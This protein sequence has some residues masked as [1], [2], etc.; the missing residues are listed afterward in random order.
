MPIF[1]N[2]T[3][4]TFT[5]LCMWASYLE[6]GDPTLSL[7]SAQQIGQEPRAMTQGQAELSKR[8]RELADKTLKNRPAQG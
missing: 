5:A 6:T 3:D 8:L 1:R 7:V 4:L 2:D